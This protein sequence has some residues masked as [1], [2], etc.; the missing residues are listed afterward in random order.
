MYA[1]FGRCDV[2]INNAAIAVPGRTLDLP[3][4]RWRL[5][6]DINLN[7]PFSMMY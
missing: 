1:E 2:L 5:A 3:T 6:V 7:G 4:R